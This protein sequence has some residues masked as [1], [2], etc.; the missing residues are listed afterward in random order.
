MYSQINPNLLH[1]YV[2]FYYNIYWILDMMINNFARDRKNNTNKE[3]LQCS[4]TNGSR[5][6]RILYRGNTRS[7]TTIGIW[8]GDFRWQQRTTCQIARQWKVLSSHV[9]LQ[10]QPVSLWIF[11]ASLLFTFVVMAHQLYKF[12]ISQ[13]LIICHY[14]QV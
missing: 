11:Y 9:A 12:I 14:L 13:R 7:R 6:E 4:Q 1:M 5:G 10:V 3:N 8:C 2:V